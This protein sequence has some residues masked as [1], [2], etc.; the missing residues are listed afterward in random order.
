MQFGRFH[1]IAL[2]VLGIMLLAAQFWIYIEPDTPDV[3]L[4]TEPQPSQ[5]KK[6]KDPVSVLRHLSGI[7]GVV[8]VVGGYV[9]YVRDRN[10]PSDVPVHPIR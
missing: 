5:P 3:N 2:A 1:G 8:C 10:R 9:I 7:I 4:Q 6:G